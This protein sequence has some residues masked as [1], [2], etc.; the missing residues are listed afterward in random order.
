MPLVL[1]LLALVVFAMGTSEFMLS[2]LVQDIAASFGVSVGTAGLL[3]SAFAVGMVIG[4]P[5]MAAITRR[6]PPRGTL[7]AFILLFAAAHVVG[8]VT[9]EFAVLLVTRIVAAFAN[10]GFLAVALSAAT[11]LVGPTRK[12]RAV[13]VLLTG[14]T[15]ATVAGVPAGAVLGAAWGWQ[16]TFWGVA[17]LCVPAAV[18]VAVGFPAGPAGRDDTSDVPALRSELAQLSSPHL[19][20]TMF[21]A[22]LVNA[23]TF[24]ALTFLGPVATEVAGLGRWWMP[25]LLVVF[26]AGSFVGVTLAGRLSD[27]HARP[28]VIAGGMLLTL[29]WAALALFSWSPPVLLG[30][31]L[32][33]GILGFGV[34][35]ALI[36]RVLYAAAGAPTMGGSYATAALNV[37]AMCGPIVGAA[38]LA[39]P[40]GPL[41]PIWVAVA[42]SGVALLIAVPARA[43]IAPREGRRR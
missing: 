11:R 26:G 17:L 21:L 22:A 20:T 4:A 12:G 14:T 27:H 2:G 8:A 38:A 25:V 36:T 3:T 13:A 15:V 43:I 34:G 32:V 18:G 23:G 35:S 24:A 16:S 19:V 6:V 30:L 39:T 33:Q 1:Y 41:G 5:L 29:G 37:G 31:V 9:T 28:V 42:A 10:A 40:L 7:L